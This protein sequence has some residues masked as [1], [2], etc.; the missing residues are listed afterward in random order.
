MAESNNFKI[1]N[2]Y[3]EGDRS[4]YWS[5][6]HRLL[7]TAYI[8]SKYTISE[9]E[10]TIPDLKYVVRGRDPECYNYDGSYKHDDTYTSD[11]AHTA[12]ALGA[13]VTL[14]KTS[15]DSQI[16]SAVT[17]IDKWSTFDVEGDRDHRFRF[18]TAP[19]L[20]TTTAF[21]MKS[22]SDKWHMQTW[23]HEE[24]SS[25]PASSLYNSSLTISSGTTKG[26]K[27]VV[28]TPSTA[29]EEAAGNANAIVG[30]Y[31]SS[32][33]V[34]IASEYDG[35]SYNAST[36]TFDNVARFSSDPG[37]TRVYI[38]NAIHLGSAASSS[39]DYYNGNTITVTDTS[40]GAPYTQTRKVID[41]DGGTKVALVDDSWDYGHIP[42]T[43]YT[44]SI[45]SI[46]DRRVT[47][48]PAM[49]LLDYMTN[50]R[51]GKGLNIDT[52][53]NLDTWKSTAR[54][55]DTRSD[56]TVLVP[57]SASISAD[58][59]WEYPNTGTLQWRGTVKSVETIGSYKQVTF[60][61]NIGKLGKKWNNYDNLDLYWYDGKAYDGG[62]SAV[63]STP[64]GSG[65]LSTVTIGN[66]ANTDTININISLAS[67]NGNPLIKKYSSASASFTDSGY[68][69]YDADDV[70]YWRYV[71]W[72]DNSQRNV[73]RH[74]MNQVIETTAPI[75]DNINNMLSQFNGILRYSTGKY[76]LDI[77]R[78]KE[79]LTSASQISDEDIIGTIKLTDKGIK[80]SKNSVSTAIIDPANK[81]EGRSIS[82]FN[83]TYLK[84]DKGIQKKGNYSLPGITNYFN[85]RFGIKQ[86]LDESRYGLT[87]QFKMA[88][89]GLLLLAG[90]IIEL[91]Y[92]RFGYTAKPFRITNLN[93]LKDGTVD[94]VADEHNDDA[95]I[96]DLVGNKGFGEAVDVGQAP[97]ALPIPARP[98]GLAATLNNQGEVVLTWKNTD[99]FSSATHL[100]EI[101]R[102]RTNSFEQSINAGQQTAGREYRILSIGNTSQAQWNTLAGT[103]GLTYS[104]GDRFT[105]DA[106]STT[107]TGNGTVTETLLAGTS[108]VNVFHDI[109]SNGQGLTTRYYWIRYMVRMPRFNL[110]GTEFRNVPS[111]YYPNTGDTGFS[112]GEGITGIGLAVNAVRTVRINPGTTT[113]FVYE[114]DETGIESG[115]ATSTTLT[116]TKTN[117]AGTVSYVWKKNGSVI[118]G[119]TSSSY[120]YSPP[121]NFSDMPEIIE[122][123]MTD[124]VGS[125]T[126]TA[127]DSVTLTGTKIVVN[128]ANGVDGFTVTATNGTHNFSAPS[129]GTI[130]SV[131]SFSSSFIV[132]K[133][134][135]TFTYDDSSPYDSNSY[136]LGTATNV[137]PANSVTPVNTSGTITISSS[138]GNFLTGTS[139]IQAT[140]D[141]PVLDNSDGSTI[142]TFRYVLT[143][144]LS[145]TV[146]SDGVRGGS[147][148]TFEESTES[149]INA[150]AAAAFAGTNT[151]SASQAVAAA[152]IAAA[153]DSTIRPNDKITVTDNS[154]EVAGT[155]VYTGSAQTASSSVNT[156]D[157]SALVVET[158]DG[159]VIVDGT[160]SA[161]KLAADTT[162]TNN[163][164]VGSN[165]VLN[166][167][168]KFY[169]TNKT[170][171]T[172]NDAGF[173]LGYDSS[174][175]KLNLGNATNYVKWDGSALTIAGVIAMTGASTIGGTSSS[176]VV[177]GANLGATANQD[178]TA[179]ILGGTHT[180]SVSGN[181]T[182]SV[183]GTAASTIA[184][185]AADGT[186]QAAQASLL[187][188]GDDSEWALG[189][190]TGT[191]GIWTR[192]GSGGDENRIVLEAGPHGDTT[193]IWKSIS[194]DASGADGGFQN[195]GAGNR[196]DIESDVVYR[197]T[198]FVKQSQSDGTLY[199]GGYN[200]NSSGSN[201]NLEDYN[202]T[203][204][205]T[206][207][208][209]WSGDLPTFNEWYLF[210]G[211][212]NPAGTNINSGKGGFYKVANG[213][214]TVADSDFR[215]NSSATQF[216]VRTY[217]YYSSTSSGTI[218]RWA[219]PRVDRL[220][221]AYPSIEQIL[222]QESNIRIAGG[223][224]S[225]NSRAY[226]DNN[227]L[228]VV[229]GSG[230]KRV[231][232]G[233]LSNL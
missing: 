221:R 229:D 98:T 222:V 82:F 7:D 21:Y 143:K 80:N 38:K 154:E 200:Y 74:Q 79:T 72:D 167:T 5:T 118:G 224:A 177:S 197:F 103:T 231:K 111:A 63:T 188:R 113:N 163:L 48:N 158:F 183:G 130:A 181:V 129:N 65:A 152:V 132:R 182:G 124:T 219:H 49:Q 141:I 116:T 71:G 75:F 102:S 19:S 92:P 196:F 189:E 53:I 40:G 25:S 109:I 171:Y 3:F 45:G 26:L 191:V 194:T 14:H 8:S 213:E 136:R 33:D 150:T 119:A 66:A 165:M 232:I 9:G 160:L 64:T 127:T 210:V 112:N 12:F 39:D 95:Y 220:D 173:F 36:N 46:G 185:G 157:F 67:A 1:Q 84:E 198:C 212:I 69:L 2:S 156:N 97:E 155:R 16:G 101:Y 209:F 228:V 58:Q 77:K 153:S 147:V 149:N 105:A 135:T 94:V 164:T 208:Y 125:E 202:G 11:A 226:M 215:F 61:N 120:T 35:F 168:G 176:T 203:G 78:V 86:F 13:S 99:A 15:D 138:L 62:G 50:E 117:D 195:S 211:F 96:V 134:A 187:P 207:K 214:R 206:N 87:I 107:N 193:H 104:V 178:S 6:S 123:V 166:N 146:G 192:N 83:S 205:S 31:K 34:L 20:G 59:E 68:S 10:T 57:S 52:E 148:F 131:S 161:G 128:G 218:A 144:T 126:F 114:N 174:E 115:Y 190:V 73:T 89:R 88:P 122:C 175:H 139:V 179:T 24:H 55:C 162:L 201:I 85:A 17:I 54:A 28:G 186:Q 108:D 23:D 22:G 142:A 180:G 233:N 30:L 216:A 151:N 43:S 172:D 217:L 27:I 100:V 145:G 230:N 137:S 4:L 37:I 159:S 18:S 110:A 93:F 41:Y 199:F 90:N 140:F 121:T 44:Y 81:F 70:K 76:E 56:I 133:G 106:T 47:I 29:F 225:G 227:G 60:T 32:A 169:T 223:A 91:T 51:Y 184:T 170:A 42:T 204:G